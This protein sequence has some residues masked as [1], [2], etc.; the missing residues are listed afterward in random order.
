MNKGYTAADI[1]EGCKKLEEA[2]VTYRII[3]LG[4]L[5]GKGH[6]IETAHRTAAVLNQLHPY[7]M[8]LTTVLRQ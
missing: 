6:G 3:Y 1:L 5:A 8:Y 7:Y 4:G 2:G